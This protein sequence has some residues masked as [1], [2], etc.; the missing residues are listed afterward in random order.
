MIAVACIAIATV[1]LF[2]PERP[3]APS[4]EEREKAAVAARKTSRRKE[5]SGNVS[6]R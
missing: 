2:W 1:L 3:P 5:A 6:K 4:L